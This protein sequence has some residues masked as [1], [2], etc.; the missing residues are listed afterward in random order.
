MMD[1]QNAFKSWVCPLQHIPALRNTW[2]WFS[3]PWVCLVLIT[4]NSIDSETMPMTE[5]KRNLDDLNQTNM[6]PIL[7]YSSMFV[8]SQTNPWVRHASIALSSA[9]SLRQDLV[10]LNMHK[11]IF[12]PHLMKSCKEIGLMYWGGV[13]V[14]W[15]PPPSTL[16]SVGM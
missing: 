15:Q 12:L 6:R 4:V 11:N 13:G 1:F 8:F 9:C 3:F 16:N 14:W 2:Y 10:T 5:E 7:P